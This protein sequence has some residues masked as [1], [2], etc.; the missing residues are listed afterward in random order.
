MLPRPRTFASTCRRRLPTC[1]GRGRV[2]ATMRV[3]LAATCALLLSGCVA[4]PTTPARSTPSPSRAPVV[5]ADH[6][7]P[8][9]SPGV[10]G[11]PRDPRLVLQVPSAPHAQAAGVPT[12]PSA[13][14]AMPP[15]VR[16]DHDGVSISTRQAY[17]GPVRWL[18]PIVAGKPRPSLIIAS[19]RSPGC[20]SITVT[21]TLNGQHT[22][23]LP[24]QC[25]Q[26]AW[27][28]TVYVCG[29]GE[30]NGACLPGSAPGVR[31]YVSALIVA[32]ITTAP[33]GRK[34]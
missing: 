34:Q 22:T 16:L 10:W 12:V 6:S 24:L 23:A 29:D 11:L 7:A 20:I 25:D 30:V 14:V 8:S 3:R 15:V 31:E 4:T 27:M 1:L 26:S 2:L 28:G 21:W 5:A 32:A 33:E 17:L 19:W 9:R 13:A 18:V